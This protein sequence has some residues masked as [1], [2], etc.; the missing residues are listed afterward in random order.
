MYIIL[1]YSVNNISEN[2][3]DSKVSKE[4]VQFSLPSPTSTTTQMGFDPFMTI[5]LSYICQAM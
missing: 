4:Q 2:F 5:T 3:A 1:Q